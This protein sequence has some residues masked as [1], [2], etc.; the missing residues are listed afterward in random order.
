MARRFSLAPGHF[1]LRIP[2][3]RVAGK[4]YSYDKVGRDAADRARKRRKS[5][6]MIKTADAKKNRRLKSKKKRA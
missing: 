1:Y 6:A 5:S 2:M 4:K 3:P